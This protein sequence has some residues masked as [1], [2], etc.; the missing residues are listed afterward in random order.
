MRTYF[1]AA[2]LV[3][4]GSIALVPR[5][6]RSFPYAS[7]L[8]SSAS[9][10]ENAD[11]ITTPQLR[12]ALPAMMENFQQYGHCN[13]PLGSSAGRQVQLV[14]RMHIQKKLTD[15]EIEWLKEHNFIFHSLEDLY[16]EVDFDELFD[17]LERYQGLH[18]NTDIK[19]KHKEDPELGAWVTGLR[20]LGPS[21]VQLHH[22]ERLDRIHFNWVSTRKC[23]S[24][25]MQQYR[26][27]QQQLQ[28]DGSSPQEVWSNE[29]NQKWIRAQR[30]AYARSTLSETR[31]HFLQQL[32]GDDW[33][34]EGSLPLL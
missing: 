14:R 15:S 28:Q 20:R 13:V 3:H 29:E 34:D 23:G 18:G 6:N 19:K 1:A 5:I 25:F 10:T 30:E 21:Q 24:K 9:S 16:H 27:I 2:L 33:N 17:R 8:Y 11:V 26:S 7:R 22:V 12:K 31:Q 32:L 4:S